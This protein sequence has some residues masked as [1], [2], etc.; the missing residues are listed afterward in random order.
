MGSKFFGAPATPNTNVSCA[1]P[2]PSRCDAA[3]D[4]SEASTRPANSTARTERIEL[5]PP[6][7]RLARLTKPHDRVTVIAPAYS[8]VEPGCM[9]PVCYI[10]RITSRGDRTAPGPG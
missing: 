10:V 9:Q 6:G 3:Q 1:P 7:R 8:W 2:C 5:T 4:T